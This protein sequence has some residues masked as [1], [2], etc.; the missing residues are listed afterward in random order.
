MLAT[1]RKP[2]SP[3]RGYGWEWKYDE[4]RAIARPRS[5]GQVRLDSRNAKDF[6]Q[7]S[8]RSRGFLTRGGG[9]T[10]E[11]KLSGPPP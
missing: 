11:T 5:D 1:A 10:S 6:T 4:A 9:A 3:G 7:A 8:L 2:P